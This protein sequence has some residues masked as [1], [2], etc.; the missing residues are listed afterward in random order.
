VN[1]DILCYVLVLVVFLVFVVLKSELSIIIKSTLI[2]QT[3]ELP[4]ESG[5]FRFLHVACSD[6]LKGSVCLI[7]AKVSGMRISILLWTLDFVLLV[8]YTTTTVH[9][10]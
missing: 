6:N 10:F 9:S 1:K 4:E 8:S 5:Q 7:L 3:Q 2:D